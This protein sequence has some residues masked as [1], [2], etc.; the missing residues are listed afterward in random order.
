MSQSV[1]TMYTFIRLNPLVEASE[2]CVSVKF[3]IITLCRNRWLQNSD[4][5]YVYAPFLSPTMHVQSAQS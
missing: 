1:K 2:Y 3:N 5:S 4:S